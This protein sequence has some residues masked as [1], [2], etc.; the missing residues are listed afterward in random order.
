MSWLDFL[1]SAPGQASG[2]GASSSTGHAA[3]SSATTSSHQHHA[4]HPLSAA[5]TPL[6]EAPPRLGKRT[7]SDSFAEEEYHDDLG[8][9]QPELDSFRLKEEPTELPVPSESAAYRARVNNDLEHFFGNVRSA[10]HQER[11]PGTAG[12]EMPYSEV[13]SLSNALESW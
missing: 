7:R 5:P 9:Q 8:I 3:S 10:G 12:S 2:A 13:V 4:P 1:G 11:A 6:P